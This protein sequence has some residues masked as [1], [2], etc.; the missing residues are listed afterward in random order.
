LQT[1]YKKNKNK[2]A[3]VKIGITFALTKQLNMIS[4]KA[5]RKLKGLAAELGILQKDIAAASK[6]SDQVVSRVLSTKK[7]NNEEIVIAALVKLI[8]KQR[9]D[10]IIEEIIND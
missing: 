6:K 7:D 5:K 10:I 1:F 9:P 2:F 3:I 8:K 4:N